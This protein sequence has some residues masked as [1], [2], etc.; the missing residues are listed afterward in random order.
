MKHASYKR[1]E[2]IF[3]SGDP[4]DKMYMIVQG[5]VEVLIEIGDKT[6]AEEISNSKAM[7]DFMSSNQ[8]K[9]ICK[10]S[11]LLWK[12]VK[13]PDAI[14]NKMLSLVCTLKA[15]E[16]FG[17]M[18]LQAREL[19]SASIM[20]TSRANSCTCTSQVGGSLS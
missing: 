4:P 7:Q 20:V 9:P 14:V 18:G 5:K 15:R 10:N 12:E 6:K 16:V 13:N 8:N 11:L 1:G 3:Y 2:M 19:R 17:Q